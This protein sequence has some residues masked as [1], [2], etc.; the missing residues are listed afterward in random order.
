[1]SGIVMETTTS[2]ETTLMQG[3]SQLS[4][5]IFTKGGTRLFFFFK[6]NDQF[7]NSESQWKDLSFL[8]PILQST[9]TAGSAGRETGRQNSVPFLHFLDKESE[10]GVGRDTDGWLTSCIL[11]RF[12]SNLSVV[13]SMEVWGSKFFFS[14]L[15][16]FIFGFLS[17]LL[18]ETTQSP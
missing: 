1:M 17:K 4:P 11:Y 9:A 5:F 6:K 3:P 8:N 16:S 10:L 7:R 14:P 12:T 13:C 15:V 18:E 2:E